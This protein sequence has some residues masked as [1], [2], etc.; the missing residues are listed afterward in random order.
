MVRP[1]AP[2]VAIDHAGIET[3]EEVVAGIQARR[4]RL[5]VLRHTILDAPS[6]SVTIDRSDLVRS[7]L[8]PR[9]VGEPATEPHPQGSEP[10]R[11][12]SVEARATN[13]VANLLKLDGFTCRPSL[14]DRTATGPVEVGLSRDAAARGATVIAVLTTAAGLYGQWFYG[15][16]F[17]VAGAAAVWVARNCMPQL[18]RWTPGFVPRG[19]VLGVLVAVIFVGIAGAVV[20]MPIRAQRTHDANL[21]RSETLVAQANATA[22][23]GD[24]AGAASLLDEALQIDP[25]VPGAEA[26]QIQIISDVVQDAIDSRLPLHSHT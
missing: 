20:A 15:L 7:F 12:T 5:R 17:A 10:V 2:T 13:Y 4:A 26:A 6:R 16:I 24:T 25:S 21:Q 23:A 8:L 3:A 18:D 14:R 11:D 22:A 19:R 1:S 9:W